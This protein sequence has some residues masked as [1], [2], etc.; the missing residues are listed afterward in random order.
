[1]IGDEDID[2]EEE[3]DEEDADTGSSED[4][5]EEEVEVE[6]AP[7]KKTAQK[8]KSKALLQQAVTNK[9][10]KSE[11][12]VKQTKRHHEKNEDDLEFVIQ[13]DEKKKQPLRKVAQNTKRVKRN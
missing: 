8:S 5:E 4:E 1:M 11:K 12:P 6:V 7:P 10:S 2:V 3:D 9:T 13:K